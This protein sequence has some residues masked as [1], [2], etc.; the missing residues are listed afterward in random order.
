M[1]VNFRYKRGKKGHIGLYFILLHRGY[2]HVIACVGLKT[3]G[4]FIRSC[5]G[6]VK[7]WIK[8]IK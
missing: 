2:K 8:N 7:F 1:L 5:L 4:T 6:C 3:V